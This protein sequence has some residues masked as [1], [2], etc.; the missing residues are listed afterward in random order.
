[1]ALLTQRRGILFHCLL[2]IGAARQMGNDF[3]AQQI[4]QQDIPGA[5]IVFAKVGNAFFQQHFCGQPKFR[6]TGNGLAHMV[7]LGRPWVM[8][9][10]AFSPAHRPAEI[11]A[12][13]FYC[14]HWQALSHHRV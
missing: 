9:T 11:P 10:S 1:M 13:G 6:R 12:Y 8:I 2:H 5:L 14:R 7:R 4:I 3:A